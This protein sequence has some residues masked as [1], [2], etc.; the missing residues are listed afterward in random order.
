MIKVYW[1]IQRRR[2]GEYLGI[3]TDGRN[4]THVLDFGKRYP[5]RLWTKRNQ[6]SLQRNAYVERNGKDE[7]L[8]VVPVVVLTV[9]ECATKR[10]QRDYYLE[11]T[12]DQG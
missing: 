8:V 7:V 6:A 9:L 10:K 1:A 12:D 3:L 5:P 4:K 11:R 2:D